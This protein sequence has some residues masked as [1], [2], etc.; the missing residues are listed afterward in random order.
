MRVL[1]HTG[2]R[3]L[4]RSTVEWWEKARQKNVDPSGKCLAALCKIFRV[5]PGR[6]YTR[7]RLD[8]LEGG[9]EASDEGAAAEGD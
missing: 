1:E 9:G 7:V 3:T 2:Q 5:A 4:S 6:F 8:R